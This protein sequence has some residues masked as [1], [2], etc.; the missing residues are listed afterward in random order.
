MT[1]RPHLK[2][3]AVL[4]LALALLAEGCAT[5]APQASASSP[6]EQKSPLEGLVSLQ[7]S[8]SQEPVEALRAAIADAGLDSAKLASVEADLVRV[9]ERPEAT[10]AGRQV[11][12][13][14]LGRLYATSFSRGEHP[15][16]PVLVA[17]LADGTQVDLARL[18]LER[19][20]GAAVDGV[21]LAGLAGA[22]GRVRIALI[23]SVGNRRIAAG[24]PALG[25]LL[26][27]PDPA[28]S[29]AAARAL[30]Q[31]GGQ[32]AADALAKA[33]DPGAA[34]VVE[35]RIRCARG[36]GWPAGQAALE[37]LFGNVAIGSPHRASALAALV[38]LDPDGAPRRVAA[39]LG[40]GDPF[41][42]QSVLSWLAALPRPG[43]IPVIA[44]NFNSWEPDTQTAVVAAAG[45]MGDPALLPLVF[46]SAHSDREDLRRAA[47]ASL[48][49]LPG[50][51]DVALL[52]AG[53]ANAPGDE[54]SAAKQSLSR[55]DGPGVDAVVLDGARQAGN[56]LRHVFL[57]ELALRNA[58]GAADLLMATH[59][60]PDV[61]VR[62]TALDGLAL[63]A[64]AEL[65]S[66]LLN[67]MVTATDPTEQT[68]A[69]RAA[70]AAA[71]RN[72]DQAARLKPISD[73]IEASPPQAVPKRLMTTLSR[74]G[75]SVA[76]DYVA[77]YALKNSGA[78][79]SA[80]V[81]ALEH[82]NDK[83]ALGPLASVAEKA[84]T[85]AFRVYAVNAAISALP[86][87]YW[88]LT[89]DDRA[90]IARLR[91]ITHDASILAR[92]DGLERPPGK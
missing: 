72:P 68:H 57:E 6:A 20:P 79:A 50:N 89:K 80:A 46:A 70:A 86:Q 61:K 65:E 74:V 11:A 48:G 44:A 81:D 24:V 1:D 38:A 82:W 33:A 75:G 27:D 47:I 22:G 77:A 87:N 2:L 4:G 7:Y 78:A 91:A 54:A 67:W 29:T 58:P 71:F 51:A 9:L 39:V 56:P 84:P 83:T 85:D 63:V 53:A 8:G 37:E 88:E 31:I 12:C 73:L 55:L 30:G 32:A 26:G 45:R 90:V 25:A 41:L 60:E 69:I 23:Q 16:P 40:G 28:A 76:A 5:P 92:I 59:A 10:Y 21:F 42:R 36:L 43:L 17:M 35:A 52:L 3:K 62:C 13:E 49:E 64:P 15:I 66:P 19:A 14:N 18:A 34:A